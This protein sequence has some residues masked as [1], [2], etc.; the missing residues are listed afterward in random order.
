MNLS[1]IYEWEGGNFMFPGRK[2]I[3]HDPRSAG[4]PKWGEICLPNPI[5]PDVNGITF[6][7]DGGDECRV[8]FHKQSLG[9][10]IEELQRVYDKMEPY[11]SSEEGGEG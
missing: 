6:T 2:I 10:L 3:L 9:L 4:L 11:D 7:N 5:Y 1:E 8:V